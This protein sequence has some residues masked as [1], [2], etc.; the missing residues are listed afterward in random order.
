[1]PVFRARVKR[2]RPAAI[3]QETNQSAPMDQFAVLTLLACLG[4][5]SEAAQAERLGR[6][7]ADGEAWREV[8]KLAQQHSVVAL[9]YHRL[10]PLHLALSGETADELKQEYLKQAQRNIRLYHELGIL[11][12]R[13][14]EKNTPV[15]VLKGAYLA[16]AVYDNIGLRTMGDIDLLAKNDDLLLIE[17]ELLALGYRPEENNRVVGLRNKHFRYI[18]P[19][20][21]LT[22]EVHWA[23]VVPKLPFRID[24][25]GLW[26]RAQPVTL[27]QAP[28]LALSPEDLLLHLCL[29]TASNLREVQLRM[30]CDIGE[31]LRRNGAKLDWQ[32]IDSLARQWG[33]L[34]ALYVILRL[35][36][37]LLGAAVPVEWLASLR[38]DSF[39]ERY[40]ELIRR[41][42]FALH[43]ERKAILSPQAARLP[44]LKGFNSKLALIRSRILLSREEMATKYP[45]SANSWRIYLYYPVRLKYLLGYHGANLWRLVRGDP[46]TRAVAVRKNEVALLNDWLKSG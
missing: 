3:I 40:L 42:L 27:A 10:K 12:R 5:A 9:L 19:K 23:L 41:Q 38:P 21:G 15:I 17:T 28:A 7:S 29:H 18:L 31:V 16:E 30:L 13:L 46:E 32:E 6:V 14:Q 22:I 26:D 24:V 35:T 33:A 34:H 1:M 8:V 25:R 2:L 39:D 44:E 45:A 43:I 20:N 11:L 36:Q 4:Y 37:E